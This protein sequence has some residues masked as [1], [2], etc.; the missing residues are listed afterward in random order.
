MS[1]VNLGR[2]DMGVLD[3][4]NHQHTY[5]NS[6]G[7]PTS[8]VGVS[9]QQAIDANKRLADGGEQGSSGAALK[10]KDS[11]RLA[12]GFGVAALVAVVIAYMI[13]GIGA[14]AVGLL[15]VIAGMIAAIFLVVAL[16]N[17]AKSLAA[18]RRSSKA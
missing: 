13:G 18:R 8:V 6:L 9:A 10:A 1:I 4:H 17:G 5:G 15:A 3:D 11:L 16:I 7:P 14:V 2:P 12:I